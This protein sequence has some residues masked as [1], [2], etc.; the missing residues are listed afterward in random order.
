MRVH[1]EVE[2]R[3]K[4]EA[5]SLHQVGGGR[6]VQDSDGGVHNEALVTTEAWR[7]VRWQVESKGKLM[8]T[9]RKKLFFILCDTK[10]NVFFC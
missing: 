8:H 2:N 7:K 6:T 1:V 3:M 4:T 9:R 10:D 5:S